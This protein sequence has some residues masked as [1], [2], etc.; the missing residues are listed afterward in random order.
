[1][2]RV[3]ERTFVWCW[4]STPCAMMPSA[5]ASFTSHASVMSPSAFTSCTCASKTLRASVMRILYSQWK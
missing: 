5:F 2:A 4:S 1:M 3:A